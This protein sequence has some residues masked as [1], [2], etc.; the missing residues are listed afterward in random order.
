[1]PLVSPYHSI[2]P[3]DREVYHDKSNCRTGNGSSERTGAPGRITACV[4]TALTLLAAMLLPSFPSTALA[5]SADA[6]ST[7]AAP[8]VVSNADDSTAAAA[9][10]DRA[11][12]A[13]A[14]GL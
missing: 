6:S 3:E 9:L 2:S 4:G 8:A 14:L 13:G 1:M 10:A 11:A 5:A 12:A 7:A